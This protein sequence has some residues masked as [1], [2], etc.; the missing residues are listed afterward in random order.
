PWVPVNPPYIPKHDNPVGCYVRE[1]NLPSDWKNMQ[2]TLHFGGVYSAFYCWINGQ[3]VGYSEDSMLPAEFDATPYVKAGK[4]V[5]SVKVYRWCDG[6]YLED[7]DHWRLSGIHRD[8]YLT[9]SPKVQIYDFFV[10]TD[11]DDRYENAQLNVNLNLKN[12]G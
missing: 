8:V 3:F 12:F 1:F 6:S 9:A 5:L 7:Q 11:L 2:L 4:N 10:R